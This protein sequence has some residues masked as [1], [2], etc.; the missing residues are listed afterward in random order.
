M[1]QSLGFRCR[2]A[3]P[4]TTKLRMERVMVSSLG[5]AIATVTENKTM[6]MIDLATQDVVREVILAS[7]GDVEPVTEQAAWESM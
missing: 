3:V 1:N 5:V 2:F 6:N 4:D 7:V